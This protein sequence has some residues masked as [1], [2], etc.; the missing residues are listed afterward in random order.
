VFSV[1]GKKTTTTC[2]HRFFL[3]WC[4][5]E[6]GNGDNPLPS[7]SFFLFICGYF[8]AKM[9]ITTIVAIAFLFFFFL[10]EKKKVFFYCPF[11]MK[12]ANS[13]K[14]TINNDFVIFLNV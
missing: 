13:L 2:Y 8:V 7:L 14:L 12:K 10:V 1:V 9:V 3:Y 11:A 5:N 6:K 4:C